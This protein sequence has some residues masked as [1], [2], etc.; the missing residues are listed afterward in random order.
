MVLQARQQQVSA[1]YVLLTVELEVR[2][3]R[4]YKF[5]LV[6]QEVRQEQEIL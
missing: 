1:R 4:P 5:L 2:L 6:A 3:L